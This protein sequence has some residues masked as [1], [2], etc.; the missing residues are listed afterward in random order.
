[1]SNNIADVRPE[2]S[3]DMP[4]NLNVR[5]RP[6]APR[7]NLVGFASVTINNSFVVDGIKV[8]SGEHGLYI[9]MPSS[10][11]TSGKW[12]D[13]CKPITAGFRKQLTEAVVEGYGA[14]I[15]RMQAT[16]DAAA[17]GTEKPSLTGVLKENADKVKAQPVRASTGKNE[18]AL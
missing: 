11:D 3:E 5:V 9:N 14:A 12:H 16:V 13:I 6:I 17:K 18:P 15:E 10:Q 8:C 2:V 4:I 7:E 1:M